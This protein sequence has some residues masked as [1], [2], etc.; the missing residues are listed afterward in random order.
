MRESDG[1]KN[2]EGEELPFIPAQSVAK[3]CIQKQTYLDV[4]QL[5]DRRRCNLKSRTF[6]AELEPEDVNLRPDGDS[7]I[8]TC[9]ISQMGTGQSQKGY[10]SLRY[11]GANGWTNEN[12]RSLDIQLEVQLIYYVLRG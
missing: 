11:W 1:E 6:E 8:M 9:E 3:I 12:T 10:Q 5:R 4:R 2:E 7:D